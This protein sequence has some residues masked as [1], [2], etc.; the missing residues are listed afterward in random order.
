MVHDK[1]VKTE[2]IF[3][4]CV[5]CGTD[6]SEDLPLAMDFLASPTKTAGPACV[7]NRLY[8]GAV[9]NLKGFHIFT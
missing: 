5:T 3:E 1:K 2:Q 8:P 4:N 9:P 7:P 6:P